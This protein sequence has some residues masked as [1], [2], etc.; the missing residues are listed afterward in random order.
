MPTHGFNH[1]ALTDCAL[2]GFVIGTTASPAY[3]RELAALSESAS[4]VGF[5]CIVAQLF[6]PL[7]MFHANTTLVRPLTLPTHPLY[8]R[9]QWCRSARLQRYGWRR[10]HFYRTRL[11]RTVIEHGFDLLSVDLDWVWHQR[12][13]STLH[14]RWSGLL[15]VYSGPVLVC[16]RFLPTAN[17]ALDPRLCR[18]FSIFASNHCA[19]LAP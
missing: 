14:E 4:A 7:S 13:G 10:S 11:W 18:T 3:S 15:P 12:W 5:R 9:L 17:R 19:H 16:F 6:M 2:D 1:A 8:P